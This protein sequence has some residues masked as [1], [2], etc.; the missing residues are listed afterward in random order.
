M[1]RNVSDPN[2]LMN[3]SLSNLGTHLDKIYQRLQD[4]IFKLKNPVMAMFVVAVRNAM[5]RE[6]R[7]NCLMHRYPC[8]ISLNP[9]TP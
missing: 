8:E 2:Q 7:G 4:C 9:L 5:Q 6:C 3:L 1:T